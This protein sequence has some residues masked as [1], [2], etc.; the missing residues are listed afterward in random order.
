MLQTSKALY[1]IQLKAVLLLLFPLSKRQLSL[2]EEDAE[3]VG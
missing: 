2:L 1:N 3:G